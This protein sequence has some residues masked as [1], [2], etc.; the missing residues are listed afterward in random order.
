[1]PLWRQRDRLKT[2]SNNEVPSKTFLFSYNFIK[3]F[4]PIFFSKCSW[5]PCPHNNDRWREIS[6]RSSWPE[7]GS[8]GRSTGSVWQVTIHSL[9]Q[10]GFGSLIKTWVIVRTWLFLLV[11]WDRSS[12]HRTPAFVEGKHL[13]AVKLLTLNVLGDFSYHY[14]MTI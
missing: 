7:L 10:E 3:L 14:V 6:S 4:S 11:V 5:I 1:M 8:R 12:E 2:S 9:A 13:W